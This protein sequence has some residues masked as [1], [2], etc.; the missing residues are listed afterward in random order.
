[1]IFSKDGWGGGVLFLRKDHRTMD[2]PHQRK[3]KSTE[4]G[5]AERRVGGGV[6][7]MKPRLQQKK[8]KAPKKLKQILSEDQLP[9]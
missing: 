2:A 1:M 6:G 8:K 3:K 9:D 7:K 5:G 4:K